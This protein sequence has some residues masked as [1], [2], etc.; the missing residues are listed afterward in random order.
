MTLSTEQTKLVYYDFWSVGRA[1]KRSSLER[2]VWG[3]NLRPVE[4][5]VSALPMARHCC[6]I[7]LK[8]AVLSKGAMTLRW[9]HK[10]VTR[11]GIIEQA[12]VSTSGRWGGRAP[13]GLTPKGA[14]YSCPL[15]FL[16]SGNCFA[17][18]NPKFWTEIEPECGEDLFFGLH[19]NLGGK[20]PGWNRTSLRR[21]LCFWSAPKFGG[22]ISKSRLK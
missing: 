9:A 3:S 4:L 22:N 6:D 17:T 10:L 1:V 18:R 7:S 11:F 16:A 13:S 19:L 15:D 20:I 14:K 12:L 8:D 2:E 5:D 21:R